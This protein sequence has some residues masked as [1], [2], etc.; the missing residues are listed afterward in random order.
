MTNSPL[1]LVRGGGDLAT[2][3]AARL[4]RSGFWVVITEIKQPLAVR[5]LVSLA[6]AVFAEEA[7][8]EDL[9]SNLTEDAKAAI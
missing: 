5:R 4:W 6:E 7:F 1:V 9:H 3:V 2:G 8:V